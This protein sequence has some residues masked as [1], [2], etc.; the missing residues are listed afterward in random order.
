MNMRCAFCQNPYALGRNEMLAALQMMDAENLA[1]YDAHCPRCRRVTQIPRQK[2]ELAFPNWREALKEAVSQAPAA[3]AAPAAEESKPAR[4]SPAAKKTA[5]PKTAAK[6]KT[7]TKA[8][9]KKTAASKA[10]KK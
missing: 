7:S 8:P 10:A 5:A 4:K 3:E 1:H 9:A 6:P 2:L